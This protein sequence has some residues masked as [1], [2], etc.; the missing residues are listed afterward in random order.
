MTN[1]FA[2]ILLSL[3]FSLPFVAGWVPVYPDGFDF[4]EEV[5]VIIFEINTGRILAAQSEQ[6]LMLPR[7]LGSLAKPLVAYALL[8]SGKSS[9]DVFF[10]RPSSPEEKS[11]KACW[12]KPGHGN[13]TFVQAMA[14]SCNA[15]FR[16]WLKGSD[17]GPTL[18]MLEKLDV[19]SREEIKG[20]PRLNEKICGL[21]GNLSISS[22]N[23]A[24]AFA[25]LFN[26]GVILN[27]NNSE[28]GLRISPVDSMKI[29]A[30]ALDLVSNGM[31][32]CGT[33][34]TG[35]AFGKILG[36]GSALVK[37]GTAYAVTKSGVDSSK[38]DG[39]CIALYPADKP[40][41]LI[42]LHLKNGSG[43]QASEKAA[44]YLKV[45]LEKGK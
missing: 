28:R 44:F 1:K 20:I 12:Y 45:A 8:A 35:A 2:M 10:C 42:L 11:T 5:E 41:F 16:Q 30:R 25:S 14:Q 23:C 29:N 15:W 33:T 17:S 13:L 31:H 4:G 21:D 6:G 22:L 9:D 43:T 27:I 7:R 37:T 39:W 24:A 26:G 36:S 34:G 19:L 40:S 38:T 32:E 18:N 3:L